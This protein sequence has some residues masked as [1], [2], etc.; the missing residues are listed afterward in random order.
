[1]LKY[2]SIIVGVRSQGVL[3]TFKQLGQANRGAT[4]VGQ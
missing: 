3:G 4:D 2:V 1:M